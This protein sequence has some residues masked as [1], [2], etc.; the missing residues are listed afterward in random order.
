DHIRDNNFDPPLVL[1]S[2]QLFNKNVP[3][4]ADDNDPSPLKKAIEETNEITLP[5]S[6]SVISFEFASLNYTGAE[7]KKYAYMLEGFDKSWNEIGTERKAV[8]TRLDPGKYMLKIKGL[9]NEGNWS[10]KIKALQLTI[11]PPFWLTWWFKIGL[12]LLIAGGTITIF[13]IRINVIKKQ[14]EKLAKLVGERTSQLAASVEE[15][16]QANKAKSVFLATMSHEIRTPMNGIIGMSSLLGQTSQ[17]TEQSNYTETIQ[18]CGESLLTVLNDILDF[19]KIESGRLELEETDFDLRACI[20]EVLDVFA[21]KAS[22]AGIDLLYQIADEVPEQIVGDPNRLRQILIN[23]VSNAIKFT[24]SG[25]VFVRVNHQALRPDGKT[26]LRFEIRDTG[27]G[28]PKDKLERLFRAFSQVDASTTRKYGGTG[29]GLVI[30]EKLITLMGGTIEVESEPD[31]GSVFSFS[32][33]VTA[34]KKTIAPYT[35]KSMACMEQ[36]RVLVVDDNLTNRKIL[37][38]QLEKWKMLPVLVCSG[39][40]ALVILAN[41][42]K[43]DLLITDMHMPGMNGLELARVIKKQYPKL[44]IMLLSSL[45]EDIGKGNNKLFN[46][47]LTKPIKESF[48]RSS[49]LKLLNGGAEQSG[50][51]KNKNAQ[52]PD[53]LAERYPCRILIAEDN[54]INQQLAIMVLTKM[55]YKPEIAENGREALAKQEQGNYD[56]IFMDMQMPEMDGL[57]A[58]KTIRS[59]P[60][61][62]PIIIAMTANAMQGDRDDCLAAGMNDYICKPFRPQEI[63]V[64]LE[65]W[66]S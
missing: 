35:S 32:I 7:K 23:L 39:E 53:N 17:T 64:L 66:A 56:I 65:K 28:I 8:Y 22:E 61:T 51:V 52:L 3:L 33:L 48:F 2:F 11:V 54:L 24:H 29:L 18:T 60:G 31:K 10:D 55:G 21:G 20:E 45:G 16:E 58:T 9:D 5:Y 25:E 36:K 59:Q 12:V 30:S 4:A 46:V 14:N 19:S 62:Q 1:T 37:L 6:S 13:R 63:A 44:P 15:A 41:T 34:S 42:D 47:V 49:I 26:A 43:F 38:A 40:E 50:P 57:E 27:I